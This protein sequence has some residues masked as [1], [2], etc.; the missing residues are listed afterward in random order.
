MK[1]KLSLTGMKGRIAKS[2]L[3]TSKEELTHSGVKILNRVSIFLLL[4]CVLFLIPFHFNSSISLTWFFL[5]EAIAFG[6]IP[7]LANQKYEKTAKMLLIA[8]I[9]IGIVILSSVFGSETMIQAF[10]IPTMGLSILLF[11]LKN[12]Q[13][14]NLSILMSVVSYFVLD[15]IIFDKINISEDEFSIIRW[16]VLTASFITTWL[17]FNTFSELRE[18]TESTTVDLLNKEIDLNKEL[19]INQK[20][21]EE[22]IAQLEEAR[23]ALEKS[24][25]A[26]S[27]FLA[28]MSH[29]IRTPMN[30]IMGMTHLLQK[31]K[32]RKDQ[33][34]P[35]SILDFSG[36]TLLSLIDDVLDFSKIEAGRLEFEETEFELNKLVTTIMETFKV[37][38]KNKGINFNIDID[39]S[40]QN[41]LIG[42]PA[43]LTQ[44]LNNLLSN[45]I[46]FT[47]EGKVVLRIKALNEWKHKTEVEFSV[48]D[49]GIG[50]PQERL[51]T[52]FESFTQASGST[53]R[54]Y[55]GTGLGLTI[56]KQLTELQGGTLSV[57][58]EQGKG[59]TF[60]VTLTF[61]K[62][63]F[64]GK[65]SSEIITKDLQKDALKG[66]KVLLAEDNVVNQKVMQ[67]FLERWK[68]DTT[69][70]EN[71]KKAVQKIKTET[72]DIILMDLQMPEMDGYEAT[73]AIRSLDDPIKRQVPIIALTAAALKEVKEKVYACG[74]NEFVTKPFN[75]NELKQKIV[76]LVTHVK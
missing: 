48:S 5:S 9:D 47:E 6:L 2:E 60:Y 21:L 75:P 52:I 38:A 25:Q 53:K 50:I 17:I 56:S 10:F 44:I 20:K 7:I 3:V 28:T 15:Y 65:A 49:T 74:M 39:S 68:V 69:I 23:K 13:L 36:K 42:D 63:E 73:M 12:V 34:E 57:D 29:E 26:K 14:R 70:V 46:K 11:D 22:N 18:S 24:T 30:A 41:I 71:G 54:L 4:V 55:G 66:V 51:Q 35:L 33:I 31:D 32:P 19:N 37:M 43:R 8:Y 72:F 64:D 62:G 1:V 45:A 76:D 58:S 27:E 61:K 67:R 40:I 59:S 16:S